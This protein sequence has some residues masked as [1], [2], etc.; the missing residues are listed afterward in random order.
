M[1]LSDKAK[2]LNER[3]AALEELKRIE[4]LERLI[5]KDKL[6]LKKDEEYQL[7]LKKELG[8][9]LATAHAE[10]SR[11]AR[12]KLLDLEEYTNQKKQRLLAQLQLSSEGNG[13]KVAK[14]RSSFL[15][16]RLINVSHWFKRFLKL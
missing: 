1:E 4:E 8:E 13:S 2:K 7:E 5:K 14:P 9:E 3:Q 16:G 11:N 12:E 15:S 10:A 6:F